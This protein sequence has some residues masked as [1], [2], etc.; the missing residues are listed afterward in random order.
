MFSRFICAV[1]L[2]GTLASIFAASDEI[3]VIE[4]EYDIIEQRKGGPQ[5]RDVQQILYIHKDFVCIDEFG[6]KQGQNALTKSIMLDLKNK[7]IIDLNHTSKII[8]TESFDERRSRIESPKKQIESDLADMAPGAQK[9]RA[10]KLYLALLD[11]KLRFAISKDPEAEKT[12]GKVAC[13]AVKVIVENAP[14]S[15]PF[16]AYLHPSL[17]LP[18][19]NTEVLY[20]LQIIGKRLSEFLRQNKETF[21]YVP[22]ELH[23]NLA[24]GG[25]LDTKV[26]SVAFI[27]NAKLDLSSRGD[28]G[29]PFNVPTDYEEGQKKPGPKTE[30]ND[31]S[32]ERP[33]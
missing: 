5:A 17:E 26:V 27:E 4:Q 2:S 16:N 20:L 13:K 33:D 25:R 21:K 18:Y 15:A 14:E 31:G 23:L 9:T 7:K 1:V 24:V 6:G 12:L 28:L 22:M 19:D 30:K 32:Q 10:E 29:S 3:L 11:D 8:V